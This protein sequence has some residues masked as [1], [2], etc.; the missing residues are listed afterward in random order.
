LLFLN[1]DDLL[2]LNE[3]QNENQ[4]ENLNE[5]Q[6]ENQNVSFHLLAYIF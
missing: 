1:D 4:N 6:K 3:N 2:F 5:N